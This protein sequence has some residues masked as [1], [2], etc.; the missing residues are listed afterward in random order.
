MSVTAD[1][2]QRTGKFAKIRELLRVYLRRSS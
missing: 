1:V 2:L